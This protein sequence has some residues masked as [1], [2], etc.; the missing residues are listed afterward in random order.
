MMKFLKFFPSL[1]FLPPSLPPLPLTPLSL[2]LSYL[3]IYISNQVISKIITNM[4]LLNR[5]ILIKERERDL[6]IIIIIINIKSIT[7]DK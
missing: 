1:L 2:S 5:T 4:H 7:S 3:D 6:I